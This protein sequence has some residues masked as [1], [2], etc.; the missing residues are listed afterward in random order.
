MDMEYQLGPHGFKKFNNLRESL[1]KKDFEK[2]KT[3]IMT[4]FEQ[5]GKMIQ[6]KRRY[7]LRLKMLQS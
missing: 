6:D 3:Q 4:Y 7:A 5:N 1:R 2:A